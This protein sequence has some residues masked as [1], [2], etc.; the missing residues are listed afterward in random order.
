MLMAGIQ[1]L[2]A[3][4]AE[5]LVQLAT[6]LMALQIRAVAVVALVVAV[7]LVLQAV[8]ESLL[9]HTQTYMR[10]RHLQQVHQL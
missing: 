1:V 4:G 8:L 9:F 7:L 3:Q 2:A 6:A 5:V 10:R